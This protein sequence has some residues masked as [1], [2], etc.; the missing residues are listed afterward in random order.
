MEKFSNTYSIEKEMENSTLGNPVEMMKEYTKMM[1]EMK[2]QM[3][4]M[5]AKDEARDKEM[6]K[7]K[8]ESEVNE[9]KLKAIEK[10]NRKLKKESATNKGALGVLK[11]DNYKRTLGEGLQMIHSMNGGRELM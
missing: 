9:K 6:E 4:V 3:D 2:A 7:L 10:E 11:N 8:K 5:K 1:L